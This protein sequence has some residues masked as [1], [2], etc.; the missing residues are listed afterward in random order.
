MR[1]I[2]RYLMA[3]IAAVLLF[4][5]GWCL[6]TVA[7]DFPVR[8]PPY[9]PSGYIG[10]GGLYV[11]GYG[12][13]GADI[14]NTSV[15]A[16]TNPALDIASAPHGPGIGGAIGYYLQPTPGGI[17]FGPRVDLAYANLSGGGKSVADA[18]N[19]SNATNY[20]GDVD[21]IVGLPVGDGKLLAYLGGGFAFGG[22]KPNL[23]VAT[24]QQAAADTSTGWN[25][26]AGLAYQLTPNW[27]VFIEGGY[28]QLGDK[29]L[30]L[31]NAAGAVIATSDT[32]FHIVTQK[33]GA[34]F[35]F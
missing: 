15:V 34:S 7:A 35:K 12:L 4:V 29:S 5:L 18:L 9:T 1:R 23:Q 26:V 8:A 16:G 21:L 27:Q 31:T 6:P 19:F 24:L 2:L 10:W 32:K 28:S 17:V 33:F 13:Y 22:A 20:L 11:S 30:T 25:G 14:T 3:A